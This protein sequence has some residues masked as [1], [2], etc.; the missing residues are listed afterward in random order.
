MSISVG[1]R[2]PD[3]TFSRIGAEGPEQVSLA[4]LTKGRKVVIFAVP[5]AFT[6]TCHSAH[7]PGFIA[8]RDALKAKGIDEI[9]CV[10][11][12]DAFVMKQWGEETGATAAGIAMLSDTGEFAKAM[13]MVFDAPAIGLMGRSKRYALMAEDG[14]VKIWHPETTSGCEVSGGAA[15]LAAL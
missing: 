11:V 8:V 9:I 7:V 6:P 13:G 2:L 5:G 14:I 10:A 1:D 15:M 12:N 3:A 4:E